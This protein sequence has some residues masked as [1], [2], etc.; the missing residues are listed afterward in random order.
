MVTSFAF[1]VTAAF[2]VLVYVWMRVFDVNLLMFME[3]FYTVFYV[4]L[5]VHVFGPDL[6]RLVGRCD[7]SHPDDV[8]GASTPA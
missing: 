8:H 2:V 3:T 4:M 7:R 5:F 1:K 6:S